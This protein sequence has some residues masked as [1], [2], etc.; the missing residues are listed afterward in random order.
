MGRKLFAAEGSLLGFDA[1]KLV[2]RAAFQRALEKRHLTLPQFFQQVGNDTLAVRPFLTENGLVKEELV[3]RLEHQESSLL[4][5]YL[6]PMFGSPEPV[7]KISYPGDSFFHMATC[8]QPLPGDAIVGVQQSEGMAVHR[9][10]CG[11]LERFST[12]SLRSLGWEEELEP[13]P[14]SLDVRLVQDQPGL[15]YKVSKVM[16]DCKVN[17]MDLGLHREDRTGAAIIRVDLEPI[18]LKLFR[19]VVSRLRGIKQVEK[20]ILLSRPAER[21]A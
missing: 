14:R 7:L 16:R 17:I 19:T 4:K 21:S 5:R 15:L 1:V 2:E 10:E 12:D 8:C 18:S 11:E 6:A 3:E 13:Q 20:I 9:N